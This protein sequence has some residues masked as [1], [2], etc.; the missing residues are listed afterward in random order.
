[1]NKRQKKKNNKQWETGTAKQ[2][3][4]NKWLCKRYPF[5]IPRNVWTGE[6]SWDRRYAYTLAEEFPRGW[7]KSFGLM[8]CEEL[9]EELIRCNYLRQFRLEQVKEKYGQLRV[10]TNGVPRYCHVNDIIRKY[11]TLSE[12]ICIV[13]GKPDVPITDEGWILPECYD[14]Y[15]QRRRKLERFRKTEPSSEEDIRQAYEKAKCGDTNMMSNVYKY[16]QLRDGEWKNVEIDISD[17]AN[18]IRARWRDGLH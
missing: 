3:K 7:W 14:C 8:L 9:R 17:T 6:I 12:N 1:M 13:C 5:L 18:K 2:R 11:S 10:Y 4:R 15:K 16:S